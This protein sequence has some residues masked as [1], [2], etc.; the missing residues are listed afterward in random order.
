[1]RGLQFGVATAKGLGVL[2]AAQ[3]A[4]GGGRLAFGDFGP[5]LFDSGGGAD[6]HKTA[7]SMAFGRDWDLGG[8]ALDW[9]GDSVYKEMSEKPPFFNGLLA[10]QVPIE[11]A[12]ANA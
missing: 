9:P 8:I 1:M 7:R 2:Q 6:T 5:F 4:G 12:H 10:R 3:R 11:P